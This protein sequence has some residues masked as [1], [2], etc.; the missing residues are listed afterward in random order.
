MTGPGWGY[1]FQIHENIK[2]RLVSTDGQH[3]MHE[4]L[5][6]S[7]PADLRPQPP[8]SE[9]ASDETG[10]YLDARGGS[11]VFEKDEVSADELVDL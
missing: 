9:S 6:A 10:T 4:D 7:R 11:T 3:R 8:G 2:M 1:R 5:S